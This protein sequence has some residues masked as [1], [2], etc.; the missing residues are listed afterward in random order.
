MK[1]TLLILVLLSGS[2]LVFNSCKK[3]DK[4]EGGSGGN[5]TIVAYVEHH[6]KTIPNQTNYPDTVYVKYNTQESAGTNPANYDA[7]FIGEAG[8]DHVHVTGLK[9]GDYFLYAVGM[10][11]TIHERV[12][13]GTSFSTEQT[14]GEVTLHIPVSE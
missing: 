5:L 4:C 12:F 10:D 7:K 1:K 9:C 3:K 14:S 11:T 6:T 2:A 8:E 13:G